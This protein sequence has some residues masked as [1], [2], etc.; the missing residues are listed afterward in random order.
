VLVTSDP[1]F[2]NYRERLFALV[3][4]NGIP[5]IYPWREYAEAGGL[6]SYG[7]NMTDAA[8]LVGAYARRIL[9]GDKPGDLPVIVPTKFKFVINLK[10][11]SALGITIPPTLLARTDEVIE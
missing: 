7:N 4:R 2:E 9:K 8:R 5:A 11:A 6:V 3:A 1:I 10:T